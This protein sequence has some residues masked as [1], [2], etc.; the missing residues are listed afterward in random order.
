MFVLPGFNRSSVLSLA[1][2]SS[3]PSPCTHLES[4]TLIINFNSVCSRDSKRD[5]YHCLNGLGN[6]GLRLTLTKEYVCSTANRSLTQRGTRCQT[7][8]GRIFLWKTWTIFFLWDSSKVFTFNLKRERNGLG[9]SYT[10]LCIQWQLC[11]KQDLQFWHIKAENA[12]ILTL[13][14]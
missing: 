14:V 13:D 4:L 11:G 12:I 3:F 2:D 5:V 10:F 7:L 8:S 9:L 6:P 1:V